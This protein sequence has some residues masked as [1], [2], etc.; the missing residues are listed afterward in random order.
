MA[1]LGKTCSLG[2]SFRLQRSLAVR[3]RSVGPL[4]QCK[5]AGESS[6]IKTSRNSKAGSNGSGRLGWQWGMVA[7]A[8]PWLQSAFWSATASDFFGPVL[9]EPEQIDMGAVLVGDLVMLFLAPLFIYAALK[10]VI[11]G[12]E[13][14]SKGKD[15]ISV[16]LDPLLAAH[17]RSVVKSNVKPSE[18][19]SILANPELKEL[20]DKTVNN[21][22][23]AVKDAQDGCAF[24]SSLHALAVSHGGADVDNSWI[25]ELLQEAVEEVRN[26]RDL[27]AKLA[28]EASA[29]NEGVCLTMARTIAERTALHEL[30]GLVQQME[31]YKPT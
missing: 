4:V 18:Y 13:Q 24:Q 21:I 11:W 7:S 31:Q 1:P 23:S 17:V 30:K 15:E 14:E 20:A 29:D 16:P 6:D 5:K 3:H 19:T 27:A 26:D 12:E 8:V 10:M 2:R 25:D 22:A 28:E 9:T